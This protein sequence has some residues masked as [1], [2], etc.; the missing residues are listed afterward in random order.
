MLIYYYNSI[1]KQYS[2]VKYKPFGK[3]LFRI[4]KELK[5]WLHMSKAK[6]M[7]HT[8]L[9]HS[10]TISKVY[11][12]LSVHSFQFVEVNLDAGLNTALLDYTQLTVLCLNCQV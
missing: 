6:Y 9:K 12:C 5:N 7:F 11:C 2:I 1:H 8:P 10:K 3:Y 4:G